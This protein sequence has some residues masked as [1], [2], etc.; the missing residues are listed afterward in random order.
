MKILLIIDLQNDF[1]NGPLGNKECVEAC[2]N[3]IEIIN[4]ESFDK[5]YLTQDT[6]QE[7]YLSTQEGKNLPIIHCIE[8]TKGWEIN[9]ELF[10]AIYKKY[11]KEDVKVFKKPTFGSI[12]LGNDIKEL[13]ENDKNLSI[14][15]VGVCTG[16]CVISNALLIKAFAKEVPLYVIEKGCACVT[17]ESHKTAI[18]AMKLCQINII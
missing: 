12:E 4:K 7:N 15:I 14:Y 1:I 3:V 9:K 11:N 18:D 13:S 6:H 2:K 5:I 17:K 8:N 16:I 10:D